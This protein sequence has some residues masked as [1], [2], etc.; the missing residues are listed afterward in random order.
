MTDHLWQLDAA[1]LVLGYR[2]GRFTPVEAAEACLARAEACEPVLNAMAVLDREGALAAARESARRY[3][4][5]KALGPLDGVPVSVKDNMHVA[6]LPTG[7]GSRLPRHVVP[8]RDEVPVAALR[9]AGAVITGKTTLSEFAMQGYTSNLATGTTRNPWNTALTPGG[10]SGG[11]VASVAAGYTPL[12][13]GTDGGGSTRRPASHCGLVGFK[14]SAGLVPRG[15]GLPE[16]FLG[17]EVTGSIAR[18]VADV[19]AL[20]EALAGTALTEAAPGTLRIRFI[21]GFADH[22]VDPGIAA[23]VRDAA[24]RLTGLGHAVE[25]TGNADFAERLNPIWM[26]LYAVGL[27]WMVDNPA[28][29]PAL[30][31]P[32]GEKPDIALCM[33]AAQENYRSGTAAGSGALFEILTEIETLKHRLAGL[34][35]GCDVLLMPATAALPWPAEESHPPVIDGRPVGPRGHA[36]FTGFVN[37]AGLT[38]I[39]LPWGQVDGLPT[40]FQLIA[41]LGG[42]RMLLA[43]SRQFESAFGNEIGRSRPTLSPTRWKE[44]SVVSSD[45]T[46]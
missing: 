44:G 36:I 10:S 29:W 27:A 2:A 41:P 46:W 26:R 4:E 37:A 42:D 14:P 11:A 40:G 34:F 22:P 33:E 35:A 24:E 15:G 13:L 6:G 30:G 38:A 45:W 1:G 19:I 18:N 17:Y 3:A 16:I 32:E 43:L 25:E 28:C 8:E 21:P 20:T 39:A 5:G 12:A 31:Y 23:Q 7:W 9:A